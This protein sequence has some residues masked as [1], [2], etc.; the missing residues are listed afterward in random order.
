MALSARRPFTVSAWRAKAATVGASLS[1]LRDMVAPI[2][3]RPT[4]P[5][6]IVVPFNGRL[7]AQVRLLDFFV[8]RQ[9]RRGVGQDDLTGLEDV[10]TTGHLE[11]HLSVLLD[12]QDRG[13]LGVDVLD[14]GED[15][16]D[17]DRR[18]AHRRLVEQQQLWPSHE[19]PTDCEHLLLA[20]GERA[21]R[22]TAAFLETREEAEDAVVV[23]RYLGLVVARVG[24]H[25]EVLENAQ[26]IEDAPT[27]GRVADAELD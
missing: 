4:N 26:A 2:L 16:L 1:Q 27:F 15:L 14:D 18:E 3:P 10:A 20:T 22:L 8:R 9:V 7:S 5:I 19:R 24:P 21:G 11:S 12:Q 25:L 13:S 23:G 17:Q 6:C